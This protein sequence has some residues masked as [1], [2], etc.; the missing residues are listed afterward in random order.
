MVEKYKEKVEQDLVVGK[1]TIK[2]DDPNYGNYK[3]FIRRTSVQELQRHLDFKE[4]IQKG[5]TT[6]EREDYLAELARAFELRAGGKDAQADKILSNLERFLKNR[7]VL[8]STP[9]PLAKR[10][11][12]EPTGVP[13]SV[14]EGKAKGKTGTL[15]P[16][17]PAVVEEEFTALEPSG[18]DAVGGRAKTETREPR[19]AEGWVQKPKPKEIP[20]VPAA[21]VQPPV[22]QEVPM[23]IVGVQAFN[24]TTESY[25]EMVASGGWTLAVI[26]RPS[27]SGM[28]NCPNCDAFKPVIEGFAL[29]SKYAGKINFLTVDVVQNRNIENDIVPNITYP[30]VVLYKDGKAVGSFD[31]TAGIYTDKALEKWLDQRVR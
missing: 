3:E 2:P 16:E 24:G 21:P 9:V 31:G 27:Y 30:Y 28:N 29:E 4:K 1:Y 15:K 12:P 7:G 19:S 26:G 23:A 13:G 18:K 10:E 14:A 11:K 20:K 5:V 25:N 6:S 22:Q 17:Q 8:E